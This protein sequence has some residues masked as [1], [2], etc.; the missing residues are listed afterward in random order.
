MKKK[1]LVLLI[2]LIL[3][4]SMIVATACDDSGMIVKN[5]K[6]NMTQVTA[7]VTYAGRAAQVD[8]LELNQTIYNF[9]YQYY[10]YYQ[11]GYVGQSTYQGIIDNI[12][13]SY[14]NAN[15]SLAQDEAYTLYCIDELYKD[16]QQNGTE[17]AKKKAAAA[18]TV[19]KKY[20]LQARIK[21]IESLLPTKDLIAA[22]KEYNEEMQESFD[23]FREAYEK[24]INAATATGKST[25]NVDKLE[26]T[27]PWKVVYEKGEEL[28]ENGL[29]VVVV[30]KDGKKVELERSDFTVTGFSSEEVK[31]EQEVTVTFGNTTETFNVEI[32]AAKPS[33]PAQ[34]TDEEEED[35]ETTLPDR[36]EVDLDKQIADAKTGDPALFKVLKEAKRRLEKQMDANYRTYDYYYLAK[37]KSQVTTTYEEMISK[38]VGAT[39]AEISAEF[40]KKQTEQKKD[41]LIG[42]SKYKD[43]SSA[44]NVKSQIVHKDEQVFYVRH[45]L[46][47]LTDDLQALYDEFK[48]E[49]VSADEGLEYYL[50]NLINKIKVYVS[51][52]EFD[53]DATCENEECDCSYCSNYAGTESEHNA[54][55]TCVKCPTK[56]FLTTVTYY[57]G[58]V[59]KELVAGED[60]T[61][62]VL[63]ISDAIMKDLTHLSNS[64]ATP[65]EMIQ[66]FDKWTYMVN[67][68]ESYFTTLSDKKPGMELSMTE[69]SLVKSFTALSRALAYGSSDEKAEMKVVGTGVGSFGLCYTEYGIHIV[70]LSG[71]ALEDA[72]AEGVTALGDGLYAIPEN[73]I[74]DYANYDEDSEEDYK[75]GTII[76][77]IKEQLVSDKKSDKVAEVKQ[78][79]YQKKIGKEAK[80]SYHKVYKDLIEQYKD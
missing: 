2:I 45:L 30:Y 79:F 42:T 7:D 43:V 18:S 56:R 59:Q 54:D 16:L 25:E 8:K 17:E 32:V 14:N 57:D 1:L 12:G 80:I 40:A 60:G 76:Y 73:A 49:K 15:K 63:A 52:P 33:R 64:G 28:V 58:D 24:E 35:D 22:I 62:N 55:C 9:V 47:K 34:P 38:D 39:A 53:K 48:A 29:K 66:A 3:A 46:F 4:A 65:T 23:S 75:E 19:G 20:N 10:S 69:S 72:N 27:A 44:D 31:E 21:E 5:Q 70:M 6:R 11:Q 61:F 51:N 68:D 37:L 78:D 13:T 26:I 50:N 36:F 41:L 71:Y 67:D 74:V 77:E